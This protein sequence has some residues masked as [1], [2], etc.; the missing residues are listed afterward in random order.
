MAK[1]EP[2]V[3]PVPNTPDLRDIPRTIINR[4]ANT[5][6]P[7]D[8]DLIIE[9]ENVIPGEA[10]TDLLYQDIGGQELL[11]VSR[12]DLINGQRQFYGLIAN[13]RDIQFKY[14]S[15]NIFKIPGS[16][17][18]HF[19]SYRIK[20]KEY[21]PESGTA[22][23]P[24]YIGGFAQAATCDFYPVLDRYTDALVGCY[25]TY[26]L[27][28]AAIDNDIAPYRDIVYSDPTNG[29]VVVDVIRMR[30]DEAVEIEILKR[31]GVENGTIY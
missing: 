17:N 10:M 9:S 21:V 23:A 7:A 20:F 26:D 24:Y 2:E 3:E 13:T 6:K 29:D 15:L 22:P 18:E 27:A 11:S 19:K 1:I 5:T 25:E 16:I 12:H 30:P 8:P 14:N 31:G 4:G 28:Q